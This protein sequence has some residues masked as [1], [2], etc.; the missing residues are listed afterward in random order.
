MSD[1]KLNSKGQAALLPAAFFGNC[2]RCEAATMFAGGM[3]GGGANFAPECD[4]CGLDFDGFNVGDG[5][6]AFLTFMMGAL[7]VT[8]ALTLEL[9]AH[10]PFWVHVILWVP[11]TA[12]LTILSLRIAKGALLILE[13]RNQAKEAVSADVVTDD[14]QQYDIDNKLKDRPD[15]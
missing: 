5:P 13:Y 12:L 3:V 2:P 7:I 9:K 6:A 10:P 14:N 11:I 4:N 1:H 8:L 15:A